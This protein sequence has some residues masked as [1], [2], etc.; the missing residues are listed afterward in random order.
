MPRKYTPTVPRRQRIHRLLTL[1]AD[2]IPKKLLTELD[3]LLMEMYKE[4]QSAAEHYADSKVGNRRVDLESSKGYH[5][6]ALAVGD[7]VLVDSP[8]IA[9]ARQHIWR[10][11]HEFGGSYAHMRFESK[12]LPHQQHRVTRLA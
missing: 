3:T 7:S 12:K 11:R 10:L 4:L 8:R 9:A 2:Y 5:F 6:Q 1:F